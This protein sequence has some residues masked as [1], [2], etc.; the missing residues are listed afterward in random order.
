MA[1]D[2]ELIK[3]TF[4]E[5]GP[6]IEARL[7]AIADLGRQ[8]ALAEVRAIVDDMVWQRDRLGE[9]SEDFQAVLDRMTEL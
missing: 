6:T 3:E 9:S 2:P 4:E 8:D 7:E 5:K 1:V